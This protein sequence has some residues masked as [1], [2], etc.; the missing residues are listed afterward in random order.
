MTKN[1]II[2][3]LKAEYPTLRTGN[4]ESGYTELND[5]DYEATI[6]QWADNLLAAQKAESDAQAAKAA[7]EAKLA[8]LGLTAEDLK[9]LGL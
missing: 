5:K 7:A 4:D 9:A 3:Q 6:N 1:E 2:E 8:A